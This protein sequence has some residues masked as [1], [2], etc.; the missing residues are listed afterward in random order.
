MGLFSCA[1][2]ADANRTSR[3]QPS[4]SDRAACG[5]LT[6]HSLTHSLA[7][8]QECR[9][10][11][12]MAADIT[13]NV[14]VN[15]GRS[16][17]RGPPRRCSPLSGVVSHNGKEKDKADIFHTCWNGVWQSSPLISLG[18]RVS[19]GRQAVWIKRGGTIVGEPGCTALFLLSNS[20]DHLRLTSAQCLH[21]TEGQSDHSD[22]LKMI[23]SD[24]SVLACKGSTPELVLRWRS[25]RQ[26]STPAVAIY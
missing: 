18:K 12:P 7:G 5:Q 6:R 16:T 21:E 14:N 22:G 19:Q 25:T 1:G 2:L 10:S 17:C 11:P 26:Q 13:A 9:R 4:S 20:T 23:E 24:V 8:L 15:R 3:S